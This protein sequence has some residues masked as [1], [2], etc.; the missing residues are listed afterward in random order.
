MKSVPKEWDQ[1]RLH[2][3]STVR[4]HI[5]Q[6]YYLEKRLDWSVD[7]CHQ[8]DQK[9]KHYEGIINKQETEMDQH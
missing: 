7:N 3:Q 9:S 6:C 4:Q 5:E 1:M 2:Y 8:L